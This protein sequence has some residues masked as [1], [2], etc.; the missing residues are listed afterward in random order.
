MAGGL[1]QHDLAGVGGAEHGRHAIE[2]DALIGGDEIVVVA[3]GE[4]SGGEDRIVVGPGRSADPDGARAGANQQVR[5]QP[6]GRRAAGGL[7]TGDALAGRAGAK[8][9]VAHPLDEGQVAGRADIGL[10]GL[11]GEHA[12]LRRPDGAHDRRQAVLVAI[13][14]DAEV[15][16]A[17][18]RIG[19]EQA[20]HGEQGV[21][22]L[23]REAFEHGTVLTDSDGFACN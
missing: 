1:Q 12:R 16:L 14:A 13:D 17:R 9:E 3:R 18:A 11:L 7:Q 19:G 6:Q 23:E 2:V 5:R 10:A 15:D 4:A 21:G 8:D 22:R 20:H